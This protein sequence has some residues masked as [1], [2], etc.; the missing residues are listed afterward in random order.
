MLELHRKIKP[1]AEAVAALKKLG[2]TRGGRTFPYVELRGKP[3]ISS[4]WRAMKGL[5]LP[6]PTAEVAA[7]GVAGELKS[8]IEKA[9]SKTELEKIHLSLSYHLAGLSRL[10]SSLC[11]LGSLGS[12]DAVPPP[13]LVA[14]AYPALVNALAAEHSTAIA[15]NYDVKLR[16]SLDDGDVTIAAGR[17][18]FLKLCTETLGEAINERAAAALEDAAARVK[19]NKGGNGGGGGQKGLGRGGG[20]GNGN[21]NG[22]GV[23]GNGGGGAGGGAGGGNG[24]G[25]DR[26]RDQRGRGGNGGGHGLFSRGGGQG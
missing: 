2:K 9:H 22:G 15:I 21:G 4:A 1:P 23:G 16:K 17:D 10:M 8:E 26:S 7:L 3:W 13:A 11:V 20:N 5:K 19:A 18:K 24:N 12:V 25:R 6:D 14:F